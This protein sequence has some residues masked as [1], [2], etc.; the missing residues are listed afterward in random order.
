MVGVSLIT[1]T[2]AALL[3][4][5]LFVP[6]RPQLGGDGAMLAAETVTFLDAH[7]VRWYYGTIQKIRVR[8]ISP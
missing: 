3:H 6:C 4:H 5:V 8:Q 7:Q 2:P 1:I